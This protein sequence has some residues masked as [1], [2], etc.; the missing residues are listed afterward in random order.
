MA[1]LVSSASQVCGTVQDRSGKCLTEERQILNRWTEYCS[2]LFNYKANGDQSV[3]NCPLRDTEDD[4]PILRIEVE[5]A[6]QSL[7]KGKSAGVDIIPA[8][9]VQAGGEDV[10][11]ALTT[12]C[13]KIWQ[14]EEW[15]T[16]WTQSFFITLPKKGNL[17]QCQNYQNNKP[18]QS[19]KQSHAEDHTEQIEATSGEDH[20]RRTGRL[21]SRKEYHRADLQPMHSVREISPAQARPLPCLH[22]LQEGFQQGLAC[23]FVGKP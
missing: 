14:T 13:T 4:H 17:Q 10:I 6:L 5:A 16:P 8:E 23:S 9:L 20:R 12:I 18:H 2:E 19:P 15:P 7:K 1:G 21:Q 22:R 3:L 11:N